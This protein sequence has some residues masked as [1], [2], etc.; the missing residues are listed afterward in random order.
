[1]KKSLLAA[2]IGAVSAYIQQEGISRTATENRGG[3]RRLGGQLE[4]MKARTNASIVV[5][6]RFG[7]GLWRHSTLEEST[8]A[9]A[10]WKV[11]K[12]TKQCVSIRMKF[13]NGV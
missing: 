6:P 10:R 9:R 1:M 7:K 5:R 11:R 2:T 4:T 12:P 8:T 3:T 13:K